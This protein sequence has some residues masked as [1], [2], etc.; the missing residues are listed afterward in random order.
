M[1]RVTSIFHIPDPV[2]TAWREQWNPTDGFNMLCGKSRYH[3][4]PSN[5]F[6]LWVWVR[7][8]AQRPRFRGRID[9]R[10]TT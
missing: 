7:S 6:D 3:V 4:P 2:L 10:Q 1:Q 5:K 8:N 9:L